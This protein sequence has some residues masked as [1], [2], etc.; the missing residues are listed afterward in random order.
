MIVHIMN[1]VVI[2][3]CAPLSLKQFCLSSYYTDSIK[4]HHRYVTWALWYFKSLMAGLFVQQLM[5]ANSAGPLWGEA[6]GDGIFPS[7]GA[8]NTENVCMLWY[9]HNDNHHLHIHLCYSSN[10]NKFDF[11][12]CLHT[13]FLILSILIKSTQANL[14]VPSPSWDSPLTEL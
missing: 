4:H 12:N 14:C 2:R 5:Q 1:V 9:L 3:K 8:S 7:Q 11:H 6:T 10:W 13:N